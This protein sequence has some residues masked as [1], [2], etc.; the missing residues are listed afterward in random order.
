MDDQGAD[1]RELARSSNAMNTNSKDAWYHCG[2][3]GSLFQSDYGYD[4]DRI[5]EACQLK[6][7][8]GMWPVVNTI[9]PVV[10]DKVASYHKT[11][12][13]VKKLSRHSSKKRRSRF[14]FWGSFIWVMML[15]GVIGFR[16]YL[17][18]A[19]TGSRTLG[20]EDLQRSLV[21]SDREKLLN[22]VLPECDAVIRGFLLASTS[23]ERGVFTVR[24]EEL[25]VALEARDKAYS[26]PQMDVSSLQRTGQEWLRLGDE[27]M[28]L[29]H[30]KDAV[31]GSE[32]DAVFHKQPD[33]WKL[34]WLHFI[35]YSEVS[36][37]AFFAG[38]G[39][40]DQAEFRLLARQHKD[41]KTQRLSD[42]RMMI[43]LAAPVWGR[44]KRAVLESPMI[45]I[46]LMSEESQLLTAAFELRGK[47]LAVSG[48]ELAPLDPDGFVRVRVKVTRNEFGGEY[49]FIMN[50]LIACHWIDSDLSGF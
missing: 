26:F 32:F 44:P 12:D 50:E 4:E 6:P 11:G 42:Q 48:G 5:C 18:N 25:K 8:V 21:A 38:E 1:C 49:R 17:T 13:K 41:V 31:G 3:C 33:G 27:W 30:W 37:S 22:Q 19:P 16:Y 39:D 10:S 47:N 34:D 14:I 23:E 24:S 15:L 45:S 20:V 46:D 7:G 35:R 9:N 2:H 29:T 36:W 43:V 28:I 40:L